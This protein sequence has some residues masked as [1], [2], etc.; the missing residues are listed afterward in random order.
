MGDIFFSTKAQTAVA[1]LACLD[2]DTRFIYKFHV[3]S[4]NSS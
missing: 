4:L 2:L 3:E 1:A